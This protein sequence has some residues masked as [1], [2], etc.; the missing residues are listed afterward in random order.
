MADEETQDVTIGVPA[1]DAGAVPP[2][3]EEQD[4]ETTADESKDEGE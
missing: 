1:A 3:V 4:D 2:S